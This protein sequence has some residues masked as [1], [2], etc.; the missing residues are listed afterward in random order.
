MAV[1]LGAIGV[2]R[3]VRADPVDASDLHQGPNGPE[4]RVL[5]L[6]NP[7]DGRVQPVA[8]AVDFWNREFRRL[9][10]HTQFSSPVVRA[11]S[12]PDELLR[13]AS[14]EAPV[15]FGRATSELRGRVSTLPAD[16]VVALSQADL[17]SFSV[18]WSRGESG[19]VGI[20]RADILPL[21]L[22]NT[23]R[24]VVAHEMGHALGLAHNSDSTTLMCGRPAS[25][26]PTAF[27][28]D[29]ARMFPLTAADERRLQQR[30]P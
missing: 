27:A 24:N 21:S 6:G 9:G 29:S 20:R 25:C 22:P 30:W 14:A 7:G 5:I 2:F 13:A 4:L 11:D 16:I 3:L 18:Q 17:I 12:V 28:S 1:L 15:G 23:V 19:I 26:R 8:D 10:R